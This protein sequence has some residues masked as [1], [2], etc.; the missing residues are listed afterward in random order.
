MRTLYID[1][2]NGSA[3][4]T[5]PTQSNDA[6]DSFANL[7]LGEIA[8]IDD[9]TVHCTG[10]NIGQV[11]TYQMNC[12]SLL[13]IGEL[14]EPR[15]DATKVNITV[16]EASC[17]YNRMAPTVTIQNMYVE[18]VGA[19]SAAWYSIA[20]A[21]NGNI[22]ISKSMLRAT[23]NISGA[24][25]RA[26][27][28]A[29]ANTVVADNFILY[30]VD[31]GG[32][33]EYYGVRNDGEFYNGVIYNC[34]NG[35]QSG[36]NRTFKNLVFGANDDAYGDVRDGGLGTIDYNVAAES[37]A[38]GS[39]G[40]VVADV[41]G[42][43]VDPANGDFNLTAA[44]ETALGG[45]GETDPGAGLFS[46]DIFGSTRSGAWS[47]GHEQVVATAN[48]S[49]PTATAIT[50]SS[51]TFGAT[52]D[53]ATGQGWVVF[54]TAANMSGISAAQIKAGQNANSAAA[55]GAGTV[56]DISVGGSPF[57]IT[58]GSLSLTIGETYSYAIIQNNTAGDTNI[59]TSTFE[60]V[61]LEISSIDTPLIVGNSATIAVL[62]AGT[63][64]GH[65][66]ITDSAGRQVGATITD[67]PTATGDGNVVFTVPDTIASNL[68]PGA[69]SVEVQNSAQDETD[70]ISTTLNINAGYQYH[71]VVSQDTDADDYL[72]SAP[73]PVAG[74]SVALES[75]LRLTS[76]DSVTAYPITL[77]PDGLTWAIPNTVPNGSYYFDYYVY[78]QTDDTWGAVARKT[79]TI[80]S[81]DLVP[82]QFDLGADATDQEPSTVI[83]RSFVIAGVDAGNDVTVTASGAAQVSTDGTTFANSVVRQNGQTVYLRVSASATFG[84]TVS[85]GAAVNGVSDSFT[86]TTR[87]ASAPS[88][89]TQPSNASVSVS[90][91]Y[92]FTVVA[93]NAQSYQWYNASN[94]SPIS[95]A[96]S[97][98]YGGTAQL[99]DDGLSF[100]CIATSSEGGTVQSSTVTLTVVSNAGV[101][102][103]SQGA[104]INSAT[105]PTAAS[106]TRAN[107][108]GVIVLLMNGATVVSRTTNNTTNASGIINDISLPA[109]TIGTDLT[110]FVLFAN[111]DG[112]PGFTITVSDIS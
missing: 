14:T 103:V 40:S 100:Y 106:A 11:D 72:D 78:D 28:G 29:N 43:F 52:T 79:A 31:L 53:Q 42:Y 30:N 47:I 90:E 20:Y 93:S 111:G 46:D 1:T 67:W 84:G 86:V 2:V 8:E 74:D 73:S 38:A 7:R 98:T 71:V 26:L 35:A 33:H 37:E 65:V 48:L 60:V 4:P 63:T 41:S 77:N 94:D 15:W 59:L 3:S 5:D 13:L 96:T 57:S 104:A 64:Q 45:A 70:T 110:C 95:G 85:A 51:V 34:G 16:T 88:I 22:R 17:I 18:F 89:T 39:N 21:Y 6:Y 82:D 56:A 62:K 75:F 23:G 27:S 9:I 91:A 55:V 87:S 58:V 102:F 68:L 69:V 44:G 61:G 25:I 24:G 105:H 54:D 80:T 66:N 92:S 108:T 97:E 99:G 112:V 83:D 101:S 36:A 76:D 49:S 19:G 32:G 10:G 50:E 81:L 109:Q 12:A 107:E